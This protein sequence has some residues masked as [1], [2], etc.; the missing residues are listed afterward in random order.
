MPDPTPTSPPIAPT[1]GAEPSPAAPVGPTPD[2]RTLIA[3]VAGVLVVALVAVFLATRSTDEVTTA[4]VTAS[5]TSAPRLLGTFG[6][7]LTPTTVPNLPLTGGTDPFVETVPPPSVVTAPPNTHPLPPAPYRVAEAQLKGQF[8]IFD[9]PGATKPMK[10]LPNP[11]LYNND[12]NAA[13]P[14]VMLVRQ[15]AAPGWL[16]VFL[17]VRP[18]GATGYV[19]TN[20]V[21]V[22][23]HTFHIE[24]RLGAFSLRVFE[25]DKVILDTKIA[26]ASDNTPT[27]GG[28]YYT[29]ML[30]K[31]PD[32]NTAYGTY[33]YGLSGYSDTLKSFNGGPGQLGIHGTNEPNRIGQKVSH[34]CIRLRNEDIEQLVPIL[35]LGVP[36]LI[37]A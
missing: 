15:D 5:P 33:A 1:D 21:K 30:F 16:E 14:L 24:V 28:L 4:A 7:E 6:T 3:I 22:I 23:Q 36:V 32:P 13:V 2:R 34:G 8:P 20:D 9:Q 19:R 37:S 25:G 18:N 17:P 10:T 26:I 35:P 29:N 27:P 31:P 11:I 12:P